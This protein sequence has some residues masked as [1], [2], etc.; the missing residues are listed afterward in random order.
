MKS[1]RRIL[2]WISIAL[3]VFAGSI[4]LAAK[5]DFLGGVHFYTVVTGSMTPT[6]PINSIVLVRSVEDPSMLQV[7]DVITFDEPGQPGILV[8]HR[9][10]SIEGSGD[11]L[12]FRT[13]G[14]ANP[15]EDAWVVSADKLKGKVTRDLS[16]SNAFVYALSSLIAFVSSVPGILLFV[17]LPV[18]ILAY[19]DIYTIHKAMFEMQFAKRKE[20]ESHVS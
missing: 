4:A 2:I 7:G 13:K 18:A 12:S 15:S 9:I 20:A 16:G 11:A 19:D 5:T 17:V 6:L 14:D 3:L 8:T 1:A 10:F